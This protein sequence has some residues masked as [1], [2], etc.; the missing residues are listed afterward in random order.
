VKTYMRSIM[1]KMGVRNR[2]AAV[3]AARQSGL[4]D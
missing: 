1:R 4:L 3:H 2:T